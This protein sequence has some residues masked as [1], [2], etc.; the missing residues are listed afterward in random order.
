MKA[1]RALS[2]I[3]AAVLLFTG[4]ISIASGI[5]MIATNGIGIP[6][7]YLEGTVFDSFL[8]PGLILAVLIAGVSILAGILLIKRKRYTIEA[9]SSAGFALLIWIFVE[10]YLIKQSHVLQTVIFVQA[11]ITLI[12][13]LVLL[14]LE[15]IKKAAA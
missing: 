13:C 10:M 2:L 11:I 14:R 15:N 12:V 8:V 7:E 4:I 3:L 6:L 1:Y 9:S 5:A